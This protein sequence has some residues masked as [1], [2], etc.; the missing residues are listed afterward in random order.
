[1]GEHSTD[2]VSGVVKAVFT[3]EGDP[4]ELLLLVEALP[5]LEAALEVVEDLPRG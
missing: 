5:T 1:M 2:D 3:L 4:S